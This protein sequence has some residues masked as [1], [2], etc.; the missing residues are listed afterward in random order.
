MVADGVVADAT[1]TD[2][3]ILRWH[4]TECDDQLGMLRDHRPGRV[5]THQA[6]KTTDDVRQ[7]D[8]RRGVAMRVDRRSIAAAKIEEAVQLALRMVEAPGAGPAV[9]PAKD[10]RVAMQAPNPGDLG[11]DEAVG[12]IPR[13]GDEGFA[14]AAF[15]AGWAVPQPTLPHHRLADTQRVIQRAGYGLSDRR[16]VRIT[17]QRVQR[18]Q[19]VACHASL[20]CAPMC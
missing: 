9:G 3:G 8:L 17:W 14:P 6:A 12:V 11:G 10:R 1:G 7:Q 18:D 15:P 20:K 2:L 13:H 19:A 5:V 4:A 16:R